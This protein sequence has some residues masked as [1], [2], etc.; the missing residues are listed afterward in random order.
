MASS[1]SRSDIDE[2]KFF[3]GKITSEEA[4]EILLKGKKYIYMTLS[5]CYCRWKLLKL[6]ILHDHELLI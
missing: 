5:I 4:N 3:F 1:T 6:L 2:D